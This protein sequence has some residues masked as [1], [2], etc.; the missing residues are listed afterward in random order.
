MRDT[1][2]ASVDGGTVDIT[3]EGG[4][5]DMPP[6]TRASLAEVSARKIKIPRSGGYEHFELVS[7]PSGP[8]PAVF[9][10]TMRTKIA[11]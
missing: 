1:T 9:R 8:S 10:W 3:L 5:A 4:P 7:E 11:E 6:R 2:G